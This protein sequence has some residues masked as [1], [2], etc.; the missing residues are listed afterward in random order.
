MSIDFEEIK[1][2]HVDVASDILEGSP[3]L[4]YVIYIN[5]YNYLFLRKN[6][7]IIA[8]SVGVRFDGVFMR[9][10][11]NRFVLKSRSAERQSFD[12]TSL[13]PAILNYCSDNN[14][15]VFFAGGEQEDIVKFIDTVE[16]MFPGLNIV[17]SCSGYLKE[18][19]IIDFI[20]ESNPEV[21][22]LGLG[23]IKQESVAYRLYKNNKE[24]LIFTCGAFITQT[25]NTIDGKYY[26]KWIDK[27]NLRWAYRI[28]KEKDIFL[29]VIKYYPIFIIL[30]FKDLISH[31]ALKKNI[32]DGRGNAV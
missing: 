27:L 22:V 26:P 2:K 8:N 4:G 15:R 12:M 10:F 20:D 29:R 3:S 28:L 14:K 32:P 9:W 1:K 24:K 5:P 31:S 7:D 16:K 6:G 18:D 21:I 13:A 23:N 25:A 17:G 30:F 19:E 11:M